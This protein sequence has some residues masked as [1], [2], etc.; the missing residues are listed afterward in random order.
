MIFKHIFKKTCPCKK[1]LKLY[2]PDNGMQHCVII[3]GLLVYD[4]LFPILII[5]RYILSKLHR[6]QGRIITQC[7]QLHG[8][9]A[10]AIWVI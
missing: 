10:E 2:N 8:A 7:N 5:L 4:G 1:S 9:T 3:V 6:L